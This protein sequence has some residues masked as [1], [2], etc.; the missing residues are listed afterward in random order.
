MGFPDGTEVTSSVERGGTGCGL[1]CGAWVEV[2]LSCPWA[3]AP[4]PH[5]IAKSHPASTGST[6]DLGRGPEDWAIGT[7]VMRGSPCAATT[8]V[9]RAGVILWLERSSR[10]IDPACSQAEWGR[11][12]GPG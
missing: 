9:P 7:A 8:M 12:E 5:A 3:K 6:M 4:P 10:P 11:G 1:V 2:V